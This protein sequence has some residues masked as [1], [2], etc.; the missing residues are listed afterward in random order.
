MDND[1]PETSYQDSY[2]LD[3]FTS[4]FTNED[5]QEVE[6]DIEE[7]FE[8]GEPLS[9]D[10]LDSPEKKEP[11]NLPKLPVDFM[12]TSNFRPG[13]PLVTSA[14]L[15]CSSTDQLNF[16]T[17]EE[18]EMSEYNANMFWKPD[19]IDIDELEDLD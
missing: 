5:D 14:E 19:I 18:V 9:L 16:I 1:E 7:D 4:H 8:R 11:S 2:S 15:L 6:E 3:R 12:E 13:T 10:D 17:E